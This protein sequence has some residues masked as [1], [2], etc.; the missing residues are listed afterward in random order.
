MDNKFTRITYKEIEDE[1][2]KYHPDFKRLSV[3]DIAK[4]SKTYE[5]N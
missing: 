1:M 3:I 4:D 5:I 2:Q